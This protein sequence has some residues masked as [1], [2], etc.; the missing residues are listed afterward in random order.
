M[1][2]H[3]ETDNRPFFSA[4][5]YEK[6]GDLNLTWLFVMLMGL[7][8]SAGFIFVLGADP[9]VFTLWDRLA[10]WSFMGGAFASVLIAS[11][12]IAKAKI[13]ANAKLPGELSRS[14]SSIAPKNVEASTDIQELSA[15]KQLLTD[16]RG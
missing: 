16:D 8:A 15:G 12:P 13:L 10:A 7:I 3:N 6:D 14:I 11:L 2:K 9:G 4:L 5:V 1:S